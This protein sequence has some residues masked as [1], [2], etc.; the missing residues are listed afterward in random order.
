M[1]KYIDIS[2]AAGA[3][4]SVRATGVAAVARDANVLIKPIII[5]YTNGSK[6]TIN[7]SGGDFTD[8]DAFKVGQAIVDTASTNWKEVSSTFSGTLSLPIQSITFTF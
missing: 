8:A 1:N 7:P 4:T 2:T 6:I 5:Q 3:A